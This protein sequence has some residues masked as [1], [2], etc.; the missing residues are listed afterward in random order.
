MNIIYSGKNELQ[1]HATRMSISNT[2]S[3]KKNPD[4]LA[5]YFY[6]NKIKKKNIV[7]GNVSI[8]KLL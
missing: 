8:I 7:E 1:L 5:Y 6:K 2:I 4:I 3:N